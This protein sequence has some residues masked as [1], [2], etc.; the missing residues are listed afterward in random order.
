MK[1]GG[2]GAKATLIGW[3]HGGFSSDAAKKAFP[4]R[5]GPLAQYLLYAVSFL[6]SPEE[7]DAFSFVRAAGV[8]G[9]P[10][11]DLQRAV[12][13]NIFGKPCKSHLAHRRRH[14]P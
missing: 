10:Q 1:I 4:S 5:I 7:M 14:L 6:R 9:L 2:E 8:G 11:S 13:I 3:G 12:T